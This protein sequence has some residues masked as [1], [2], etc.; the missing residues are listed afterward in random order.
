MLRCVHL[1]SR[2]STV[3]RTG[4]EKRLCQ[5]HTH[6]RH[7]C[8]NLLT[9]ATRIG[10]P[11]R[12]FTQLPLSSVTVSVA[13][14]ANRLMSN[15]EVNLN[16]ETAELS[17]QALHMLMSVMDARL[18]CDLGDPPLAK[19]AEQECFRQAKGYCACKL[20]Q[21]GSNGQR[22][23]AALM[24]LQE[25]CKSL[26][27]QHDLFLLAVVKV[28]AKAWSRSVDARK[29]AVQQRVRCDFHLV[30]KIHTRQADKDGRAQITDHFKSRSGSKQET[31]RE[32][33]RENDP[34]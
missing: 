3:V 4:S 13:V 11:C 10:K 9:V 33:E 29:G 25:S 32:H 2:C 30:P 21:N 6:H 1:A 14:D 28:V 8:P 34:I 15:L 19:P 27:G 24:S 26:V 7:V 5:A 17:V 16:D 31:Q 20:C 18:G 23:S 12:V 22:T